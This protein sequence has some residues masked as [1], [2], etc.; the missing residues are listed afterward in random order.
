MKKIIT[1]VLALLIISSLA[2]AQ[3]L[4]NKQQRQQRGQRGPRMERPQGPQRNSFYMNRMIFGIPEADYISLGLSEE[5]KAKATEL[6]IS[7]N[8]KYMR[9]PGTTK[10]GEQ[11]KP[12]TREET[13]KE[14]IERNKAQ[15]QLNADFKAL[16]TEEQK[17][18]YDKAYE[19]NLAKEKANLTKNI[20]TLDPT[21]KFTEEQKLKINALINTYDGDGWAYE[22]EF[23]KI[24]TEEQKT[25]LQSL[26]MQNMRGF[27]GPNWNGENRPNGPKGRGQGG[28]NKNGRNR[29]PRNNGEKR[30]NWGAPPEGFGPGGPGFNPNGMPPEDFDPNAP[31]SQDDPGF[32][33]GGT[34]DE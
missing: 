16:L 4:N 20:E 32:G 10:P 26:R 29:G 6:Q 27:G 28:P 2:M 3:D 25:A 18:A 17:A 8:Q 1:I 9:M 23:Q 12:K 24:L 34:Y 15:K 7:F 14:R 33:P 5:Q 13:E 11:F 30:G 22:T 21:L 31:I 19:I